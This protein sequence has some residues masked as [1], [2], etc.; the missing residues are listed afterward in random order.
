MKP[1]LPNE[2][3]AMFPYTQINNSAV[4]FGD[5]LSLLPNLPEKSI[6]LILCDLPYGTTN[7]KWDILIDL[8]VL[9]REYKRVIKDKGVIL[10]FAQAPFDKVLACSNL[11]MFRYEWIWEKTT[12]TGH[13]NAKKMPMK[14]HENILVFYKSLPTYNPIMTHG[15]KRKVSTAHHK[16]NS[17]LGEA[18]HS[19]GLSG[20]DSTSRYP[21]DVLKFSMDKQKE[22]YHCNQKPVAL[23]EYFIN[24]YTNEGDFVLDNCAGSGTTAVA[25]IRTKRRY[26][27]MEKDIMLMNTINERIRK[28]LVNE[29][30]Y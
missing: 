3:Q 28:A 30:T 16:R 21:R 9:W 12:A 6:D 2:K 26:I 8:P 22:N 5:C 27:L 14:A 24:T 13:L 18:Y 25:S 10:L 19:Y 7:A 29:R 1:Q 23:L 4:Y 11:S 20:Y 17:K 15:H